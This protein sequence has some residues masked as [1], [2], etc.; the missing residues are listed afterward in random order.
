MLCCMGRRA[1]GMGDQHD[2]LQHT[3]HMPTASS[4]EDEAEEEEDGDG[5]T[6][7]GVLADPSQEQPVYDPKP[8]KRCSVLCTVYCVESDLSG[9]MVPPVYTEE[10]RTVLPASP[11]RTSI[12]RAN[13]ELALSP[14]SLEL[15]LSPFIISSHKVIMSCRVCLE[16]KSI[17]PLPCCK[18]GVCEDCLKRYLSS[19]VGAGHSATSQPALHKMHPQCLQIPLNV[20]FTFVLHSRGRVWRHTP[21]IAALFSLH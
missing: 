19:Q 14:A 1:L 3:Q 21:A 10:P 12:H 17:K 5:G 16:D 2:E 9:D 15:E 20:G 8:K 4:E 7:R 6:D 18:K 13:A 11:S